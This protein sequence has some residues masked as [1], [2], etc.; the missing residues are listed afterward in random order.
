MPLFNGYLMLG[1]TTIY[2]VLPVF[3]LI[4]D[5]DVDK[6][7]AMDFS[8]LYKNLQKGRELTLKTFLIWIMLSIY[9]AFIIM[10]INSA[11]FD[12][13]YQNF[14]SITFTS[15]I[16]VQLL[17]TFGEVHQ[18]NYAILGSV[19]VSVALYILSFVLFY[20]YLGMSQFSIWLVIKSFIIGAFC[21]YPIAAIR[22]VIARMNPSE[23]YKIMKAVS[24]KRKGRIRKLIEK[25]IYCEKSEI[26]LR[27]I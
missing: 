26:N 23:E 16:F 1:Y 24:S 14:I 5:E 22:R 15:L 7:T 13:P 21:Y 3:A 8:I 11:F 2:T 20:D 6:K 19:A 12:N 10:F 18:F 25:Y 4:Y 17:N 9:Q 27:N